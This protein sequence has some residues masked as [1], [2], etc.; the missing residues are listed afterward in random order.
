MYG[1]PNT[2]L[3][4]YYMMVDEL[5]LDH[6]PRAYSNLATQNCAA[7]AANCAPRAFLKHPFGRNPVESLPFRPCLATGQ[8]RPENLEI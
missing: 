2:K 3:V 1:I 7:F 5:T 6:S 4:T 8:L